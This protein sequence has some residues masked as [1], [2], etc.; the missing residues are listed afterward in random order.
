MPNNNAF[1]HPNLAGYLEK[2]Q[3]QK[4]YNSFCETSRHLTK[5]KNG[6]KCGNKPI[7]TSVGLVNIIRESFLFRAR[8]SEFLRTLPQSPLVFKLIDTEDTLERLDIILKFTKESLYKATDENPKKRKY[9]NNDVFDVSQS[10]TSTPETVNPSKRIRKSI[11]TPF[12]TLSDNK[13]VKSKSV[14]KSHV[15]RAELGYQSSSE[16]SNK[17]DDGETEEAIDDNR[18]NINTTASVLKPEVRFVWF[19]QMTFLIDF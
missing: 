12:L 2:Q 17:E 11:T 4:A 14:E 10:N 3:L 7:D 18:V 19:I 16:T 8:I 5:E 1:L 15:N 6:L 13:E 9:E